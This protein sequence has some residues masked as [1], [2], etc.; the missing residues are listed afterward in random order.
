MVKKQITI[1]DLAGMVKRGFDGVDKQF[2]QVA[3][4]FDVVDERLD[5]IEKLILVSH[6]RRIERLEEEVKE[7]KNL[8]AIK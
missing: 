4:R 1:E 2:E 7:I 8:F 3:K 5:R 6:N